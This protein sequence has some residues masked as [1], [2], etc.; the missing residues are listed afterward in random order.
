MHTTGLG[1]LIYGGT[2]LMYS[3][4][5][6]TMLRSNNTTK[7]LLLDYTIGG[8]GGVMIALAFKELIHK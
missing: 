8:L 3:S 7:D 2:S 5:F 6:K 1:L 4:V